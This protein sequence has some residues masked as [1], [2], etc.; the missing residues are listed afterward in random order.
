MTDNNAD[1]VDPAIS[2]SN[3]VWSQWDGSDWEIYSNFAEQL[4]DNDID[5]RNPDISGTNVVW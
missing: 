2:G 3:V 1:D 5:D 4:T